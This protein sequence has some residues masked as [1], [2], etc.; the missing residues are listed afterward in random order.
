MP[1]KSQRTA[2]TAYRR[3]RLT[4]DDTER[5]ALNRSDDDDKPRVSEQYT[6]TKAGSGRLIT[7]SPQ[8]V[9]TLNRLE[10]NKSA[11]KRSPRRKRLFPKQ[12]LREKTTSTKLR[13]RRQVPSGSEKSEEKARYSKTYGVGGS[14]SAGSFVVS[15]RKAYKR[16]VSRK[17]SLNAGSKDIPPKQSS[18]RNISSGDS[19]ATFLSFKNP[20]KSPDSSKIV[21]S[22]RNKST[23]VG[24][25]SESVEE[26]IIASDDS[27]GDNEKKKI[28]PELISLLTSRTRRTPRRTKAR[29]ALEILNEFKKNR[30]QLQPKQG[31]R[32]S[33]P[34]ACKSSKD[35]VWEKD[36]D[37]E[38]ESK[39]N[40][41]NDSDWTSSNISIEKIIQRS[42]EGSTKELTAADGS[43]PNDSAI[44][45]G[46]SVPAT[47]LKPNT[48]Q[49]KK[50]SVRDRSQSF[51]RLGTSARHNDSEVES[52]RR[53]LRKRQRS[54]SQKNDTLTQT[55]SAKSDSPPKSNL[56]KSAARKTNA[57]SR[58]TK[59]TVAT[60]RQRRRLQKN[61]NDLEISNAGVSAS[62]A[63]AR[64]R[65]SPGKDDWQS[66]K[67]TS[68]SL[69][70]SLGQQSADQF[71][72]EFA[73]S[74]A[75]AITIQGS[76]EESIDASNKNLSNKKFSNWG[77]QQQRSQFYPKSPTE[78]VSFSNGDSRAHKSPTSA[79]RHP[80]SSPRQKKEQRLQ[81]HPGRERK[82][83]FDSSTT[84]FSV[85]IKIKTNLDSG[86]Q[87]K[88]ENQN[89]NSGQ[90]APALNRSAVQAIANQVT[91]AC[92]TQARTSAGTRS[93]GM[94]N[95]GDDS[96]VNVDVDVH[97]DGDSSS[98]SSSSKS[99]ENNNAE[100]ELG[101][102]SRGFSFAHGI[103]SRKIPSVPDSKPEESYMPQNDFDDWR[104]VTSELTSDWNRPRPSG[105]THLEGQRQHQVHLFGRNNIIHDSIT[106]QNHSV[107][108]KHNTMRPPR[109]IPTS[110]RFGEKRSRS[111]L[112]RRQRMRSCADSLA[113]YGIGSI[114]SGL[115]GQ[116]TNK[117]PREVSLRKSPKRSTGR[118]SPRGNLCVDN[119]MNQK[120]IAAKRTEIEDQD[121]RVIPS[122]SDPS[123]NLRIVPFSQTNRCGKCKGC[124]RSFDCQT[125]GV[126]LEKL[127]TY[128][129]L[130]PP[131]A[132]K[133]ST[134]C[135]ERRCQRA[136]RIGFVDSLLG[137]KSI[138]DPRQS[139]DHRERSH[140]M[141]TDTRQSTDH[142]ERSHTMSTDTPR[143]GQLVKSPMTTNDQVVHDSQD[144]GSKMMKAPWEEGDDWTV[145]YSYLSE[146]EYR[147]HWGMVTNS[148][149][150]IKPSSSSRSLSTPSWRPSVGKTRA[151]GLFGIGGGRTSLSSSVSESV[152]SKNRPKKR[153]QS[154]SMSNNYATTG[155]RRKTGKRKRDP[156]HGIALPRTSTD[157]TSVTSWR[158]NRKC[159]RALMEYDEADQDWV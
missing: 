142:R 106:K 44:E 31:T 8:G 134:L 123:K 109:S 6:T 72:S 110:Q 100:E 58:A 125:C 61:S 121:I 79:K 68:K 107:E 141:S 136:C 59:D 34:R 148:N 113:G 156:L 78:L 102:S 55:E 15:E 63:V 70:K 14:S 40:A 16:G 17:R 4:W 90:F 41:D 85:K 126:C 89:G 147:R 127:H 69:F 23:T 87:N 19:L 129:S 60:S 140:A 12:T 32:T 96:V 20:L 1:R 39:N 104:S 95:A 112:S 26:N 52:N 135:L 137:T 10:K 108:N 18:R 50:S 45:T 38:E 138:V 42:D 150:Q 88:N 9:P 11:Q 48:R 66:Q 152:L 144:S 73:N 7:P 37:E 117:I 116:N 64:T 86:N 105:Q 81:H 143:F 111:S 122:A 131:S 139:T 22:L 118:G 21:S 49:S 75:R 47:T 124:R 98:C 13:S 101:N 46:V 159:L 53:V 153:I 115:E 43:F 30:K 114:T 128:G 155:G 24:R 99:N 74:S 145:D 151:I 54:N 28:S 158:E 2:S 25:E 62:N 56:S 71:E 27:Q 83:R 97:G 29:S 154:M 91:Q 94:A 93:A 76:H 5:L 67:R 103:F 36:T 77:S 92:L 84:T 157:A 80:R 65:S 119:V 133:E 3:R 82:V 51:S 132:E 130:Q 120:G 35:S 57:H 33:L 146:P 149:E